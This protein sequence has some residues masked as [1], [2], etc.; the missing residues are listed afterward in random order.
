MINKDIDS[1]YIYEQYAKFYQK[2]LN[3]VIKLA[4]TIEIDGQDLDYQSKLN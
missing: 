3:D 4:A 1:G 2:M